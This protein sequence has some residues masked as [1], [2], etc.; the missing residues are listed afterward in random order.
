MEVS[1]PSLHNRERGL[2]EPLSSRAN[3]ALKGWAERHVIADDPYDRDGQQ[4]VSE[5]E[6]TPI[7]LGVGLAAMLASGIITML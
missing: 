5:E 4:Q 1:G 7:W 2:R 6:R 3:D